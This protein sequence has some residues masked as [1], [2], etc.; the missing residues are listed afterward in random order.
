[1]WSTRRIATIAAAALAAVVVPSACQSDGGSA[2]TDSNGTGTGAGTAPAATIPQPSVDTLS[3]LTRSRLA[4]DIQRVDLV[5]PSFSHPT[6]VT[7]PLFPIARLRSA[8]LVGEVDGEPLKVETTLLPDT[9]TI[10]WNGRRVEALQS[11]FIAYLNGRITESAVDLY[12]QA[13]DG[14]V[15]YF[16]EDVVDY[17]HGVAATTEGTWVVGVDGPAAMIMPGDPQVGDVFRSENIPGVAFEEV[18]VKR[19]GVTVE[20]PSGPIEGAMVGEELHM[21]GDLEDKTFAPA[22][23]EFFSGSGDDFEANALVV[24][25]D[26]LAGPVPA[27]LET[28]SRAADDVLDAAASGDWKEASAAVESITGAWDAFRAGE[29]PKRLGSRMTDAVDALAAAVASQDARRA[30][31]AS[32]GVVDAALDLQLRYRPPAEIDLARLRLWARRL[33]VDAAAENAPAVTGD[34]T[35]LRWILDRVALNGADRRGI[36]DRLRH[37]EAVAEAQEFRV[38]MDEAVRLGGTVAALK[39]NN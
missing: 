30:P 18:T 17:A 33:L 38:A 10:E 3:R 26:A 8:I 24:P 32:L 11:Q 7:N 2:P 13:D 31:Q 5:V 6:D 15:W 29:V 14:A 25:A 34:V 9:K 19:I 1:M 37:L 12:A 22:Y 21:E 16:G 27:E 4:P 39:P 23:G 36:E 28:V 20:G 35:T